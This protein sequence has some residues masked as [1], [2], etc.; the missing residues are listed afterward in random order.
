[1]GGSGSGVSGP[2]S[3]CD[4]LGATSSVGGVCSYCCFR[5]PIWAFA[6]SPPDMPGGHKKGAGNGHLGTANATTG[7][8]SSDAVTNVVGPKKDATAAFRLTGEAACSVFVET[9]VEVFVEV[10]WWCF[11]LVVLALATLTSAATG[12]L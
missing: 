8:T 5:N 12:V 9:L 7:L 3:D 10:E 4:W 11:E 1:M 2:G 6:Q